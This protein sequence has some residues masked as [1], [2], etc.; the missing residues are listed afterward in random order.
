MAACWQHACPLRLLIAATQA[1]LMLSA[2]PVWLTQEDEELEAELGVPLSSE[3]TTHPLEVALQLL[4]RHDAQAAAQLLARHTGTGK[5]AAAVAA[6]AP[7][8]AAAT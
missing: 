6:A 5:A 4:E 2:Q 8:V 1:L 3:H 7:R